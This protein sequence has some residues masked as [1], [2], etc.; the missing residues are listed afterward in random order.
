MALLAGSLAAQT[1]PAQTARQGDFTI[2]HFEFT[3]GEQIPELKLHYTT[4]G[5]AARDARGH[6]SNAVLILHG[7]GGSGR[8]F[9][10]PPF[11]GELF[12]PGQLLDASKYFIILPDDIGHGQSSKPSDGLRARFPHYGYTDMV[13]AEYRLVTDGLHVDHLRLVMGTSM[14]CMHSWLWGER[15]PEFMDALMPLA[16]LPVPIAGRNRMWRNM[17]M[18]SIRNDP[19]WQAGNYR[20]QPLGLT[21]AIYFLIIAGSSPP[22]G[23]RQDPNQPRHG[24]GDIVMPRPVR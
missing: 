22:L 20:H 24:G 12:G 4:L 17:T 2:S 7:T 21:E 16:C 1:T 19:G 14:G 10:T 18:D 23:C 3:D 8:Q 11:A 5:S 13:T 9:L 15:N 6:I